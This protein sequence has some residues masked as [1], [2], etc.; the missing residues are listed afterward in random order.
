MKNKKHFAL[1]ILG[2]ISLFLIGLA[3]YIYPFVADRWNA[4]RNMLLIENY[5]Q[6]VI[7]N[8]P[9]ERYK[10]LFKKAEAYNQALSEQTDRIMFQAKKDK[11]Y[12]S[13]LNLGGDG[14]MGYIEIPKIQINIPIYHYTSDEVL[15]KGIGH[16]Q[17]S[18][19]PI[20]GKTTRC[21]LTGHRGLPESK[22]FTDLDKVDIGDMFYIHVLDHNLA[23]KVFNITTVLPYEIDRLI[24]R[25]DK[26]LVTLVTCT[27]YGVNTHR[28]LVTGKR[29]KFEP[30]IK[31]Q[32][33]KTGQEL[34]IKSKF[35][36]QNGL[37]VGLIVF[38]AIIL[39][40]VF[41]SRHRRKKN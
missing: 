23:Y 36:P 33:E 30:E 22:L 37:V 32:E 38:M 15:E 35:T 34:E 41:I 28:L 13:I 27:P 29:V 9:A 39:I 8:G 6:V 16:I 26:D 18:S 2:L 21:I 17:G 10:K 31:E 12:E 25:K 7:D 1:T 20:G 5:E 40:S 24:F 14:I 4:Y 11:E 19:L 3:I